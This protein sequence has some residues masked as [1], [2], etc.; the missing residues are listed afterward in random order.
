MKKKYDVVDGNTAASNVAYAFS[1]VSAIYPITPSSV[2]GELADE[3]SAKGRKNMFGQ[4]VDVIEM[5]SEGGA[6]GAIHGSLTA[7]ALT[8]TYTASQGLLLMIP[9]MFKIAGEL[10]PT[11]FHVSARALACQSLSIYG[12]HS[13]VMAA[14]GTG[15]AMIASANSQEAQDLAIIA[16][17]STLES[18]VPFLHFFDG[19]RTSHTLEKIETM[20]YDEIKELVNPALIEDFRKIAINPERPMCKVGA[21]NPDV[22]FQG[23]EKSNKNYIVTPGIVK[24]YMDIFAKKTGRKYN[25]FDYY[26]S[27]NADK[28]IVIMGSGGDAVE[29]TIDYLQKTQKSKKTEEKIGVVKVRLYRPFSVED[30][31]KTLPKTVKRI[32]VL[33]RTK[34]PGSIGEPLYLDVVSAVQASGRSIKIIGGRYGL[35]S[36][37]FTP[38]MVNAVY[39]HLAGKCTHNFT[40]GIEDD[41]TNLSLKIT[42]DIDSEIKGTVRCKFWGFGSDGTVS[43]NKNSIKI[44]GDST[45]KFVQAYFEYDSKKSGGITVSHL[46]FSDNPI[47][48][49]Y[50]L[51][52]C[53]FV[54]LHKPSYIGQYDILGGIVENGTFLL[55][56]TAPAEKA[57]ET[58]TKSMQE[59]LIKKKINFYVIDAFKIANE[60]GLR[61]RI[62]TIMQV[63]FFKIAN[64]IPVDRA[65]QLIKDAI[66]KEFGRKGEE[67]VKM[68]WNAV[69]KASSA[70]QKVNIPEKI[71]ELSAIPALPDKI[72]IP[73]D[74]PQFAKEIIDPIMR[75]NGDVI[76]VAEMPLDGAVPIS[77][78]KLEK[79]GVALEVPE[80]IPEKCI[81]CGN[82]SL[83]CPHAA[84]RVKQISPD[85]LKNAPAS[86]KTI[87]ANTKN[88]KNLQYKVQVY[89]EDCMGCTLCVGICPPKEKA[90]KMVALEEARSKN[91]NVNQEFFERIA[92]NVMDGAIEGTV[93]W[94][95]L[96][97]PLFEFSGACAGCGETPYVK[98]LTQLHGDRMIIANATGCSSIYGGTFPT[99]PYCANKKGKGPAWANSLFE[100]NAEY[101]FGMRLAVE[102]N[103]RQLFDLLNEISKEAIDVTFKD[104]VAKCISLFEKVDDEAKNAASD[105]VVA[106]PSRIKLAKGLLKEK[107]LKLDSLKD[108]IVDK[109][110]WSVGGDGWAYDIGYGGLDHVLAQGRKLRVLVL[111]TEV[112]SNTGGQSSKSTPLAATAKFAA[113]GKRSGKKN[114][115]L[116]M[117]TYGN[118][119]VASIALGANTA[120]AIKAFMEAEKYDGPS[121]IIAYSP[122]I[123]HGFDMNKSIEEEKKAV[124]SG[125]WPLYRFNPDLAKEG[126]SPLIWETPEPKLSFK[127][128]LM[129]EARYKI[130]Y[131]Q[132]QEE[133]ERLFKIAEEDAKRRFKNIKDQIQA[134]Q[135]SP[136]EEQGK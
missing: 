110:V 130:L 48:S 18:R 84:I 78:S 136:S 86:F 79:R 47:K 99:I 108:F 40:V 91:E 107:L 62:N 80:W 14:R 5:Q 36:K 46:R 76:S 116:M 45:D 37:N 71:S 41:F 87:K 109:S 94:T 70:L 29:E 28:V 10:L 133:A 15:F 120:Q 13:D 24:K 21:Q 16:H 74:A 89:P 93:K 112:Y 20:E 101:G 98:L 75:F 31:L 127:D 72:L 39:K 100:D 51:K 19:F 49:S 128:F 7:G 68:N 6:A 42:E 33:D 92:D 59:T 95:Q 17:L 43:A 83:V 104:R 124:A 111:D 32:A 26:G 63:A 81:Q 119:Y 64:I 122:C 44:I 67:I 82:C 60:V 54:A 53:D 57:F 30:F 50:F 123:A 97:K 8:T 25:L 118:V 77:T 22:Y 9:N 85:E 61:G 4:V 55:N 12:D 1:E 27:K 65:I 2:M 129:G 52:N 102:A 117:M 56:T 115:G 96:K 34:E 105:L 23:R 114:L 106:L 35:S 11:V 126:K 125:Y 131:L 113:K 121:I 88:D 58:L 66:K 3:W 103:R 135:P 38:S 73:K 69:D 132:N 134:A 90:L